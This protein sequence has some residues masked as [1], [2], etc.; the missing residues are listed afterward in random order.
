MGSN[1]FQEK[2]MESLQQKGAVLVD[3]TGTRLCRAIPPA[4]L[5]GNPRGAMDLP[6]GARLPRA[7][8]SVRMTSPS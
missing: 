1:P 4:E 3:E 7:A 5:L 8:G 6:R 2:A